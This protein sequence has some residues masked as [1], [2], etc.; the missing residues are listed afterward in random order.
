MKPN[1]LVIEDE[2][3][4]RNS[5]AEKLG[6]EDIPYRVAPDGISGAQLARQI[7]PDLIICDI[8]MP[9]LDGF[10]VLNEL[11]SDPLTANIPFVFLTAKADKASLRQGMDLGADDYLTKPVTSQELLTTIDARLQKKRG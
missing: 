9:G 8:M 10:G 2:A 11:R 6:Y 5:I 3:D 4:I 1:I 7:V